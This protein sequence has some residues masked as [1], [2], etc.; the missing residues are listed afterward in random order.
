[1]AEST[2]ENTGD[3]GRQVRPV[4]IGAV[5]CDMD[6]ERIFAFLLAVFGIA[7]VVYALINHKVRGLKGFGAA[8]LITVCGAAAVIVSLLLFG[9]AV[10]GRLALLVLSGAVPGICLYHIIRYSRL[11]KYGGRS[12]GVLYHWGEAARMNPNNAPVIGYAGTDGE[13]MSLEFRSNIFLTEKRCREGVN[14]IF[15]I[16]HSERA[17]VEKYSLMTHIAGLIVFAPWFII[18]VAISL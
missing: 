4:S 6:I 10:T 15:D 8:L 16:E 9:A 5:L 18:A 14:V 17:Y 13:E 12:E 2:A 7:G 11:K 1:L 3:T